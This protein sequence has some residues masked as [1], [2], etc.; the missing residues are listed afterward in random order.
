MIECGNGGSIINVA[1]RDAFQPFAVGLG[2]YGASKG[3]VVSF[4]RHAA[5]EYAPHQIRV[6]GV[7]PGSVAT[8]GAIEGVL[9]TGLD[10]QAIEAIVERN[11]GR[12]PLG[13]VATSDEIATVIAFLASDAAAMITGDTVIADGGMLLL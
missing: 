5:L 9:S 10:A 12:L 8:E 13:R 2:T 11:L 1:S 7:A 4:T 3:A 6:S